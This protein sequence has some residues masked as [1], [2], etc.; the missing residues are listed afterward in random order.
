L[1]GCDGKCLSSRTDDF[2]H[3]RPMEIAK[4]IE[5]IPLFKGLPKSQIDDLAMIM[6]DQIFEKGQQIFT[7]GEEAKGFYVVVDGR[8]KIYKVSLDGKELILHIFGSGNPFGEVPV[9]T[10]ERFPAHAAAMERSRIFF[11]PRDSFVTLIRK[12]PDLALN[13]LAILAR[14]LK[15]FAALVEELSLKEVP[16][17]VATH[18][19]YLSRLNQGATEFTLDISKAQFASLLG[20]IPE[21]LSRILSRMK[22]RGLIQIDGARI[23]LLDIEGLEALAEASEKL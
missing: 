8:V 13:M 1:K 12:N 20:T 19:L 11:F 16:G 22:K 18:L 10:G 3:F 2:E 9:F 6:A 14:R 23:Q 21:T 17:R 5:G 7:E 15:R 4:I